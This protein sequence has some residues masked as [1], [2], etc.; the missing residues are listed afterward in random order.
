MQIDIK[1]RL[2]IVNQCDPNWDS[3]CILKVSWMRLLT[4]YVALIFRLYRVEFIER[5]GFVREP[6]FNV[7]NILQPMSHF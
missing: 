7:V 5:I 1:I 4:K 3:V 2:E 6:C